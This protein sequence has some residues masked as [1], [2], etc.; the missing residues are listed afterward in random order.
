MRLRCHK[1]IRV[2]DIAHT[3]SLRAPTQ[4]LYIANVFHSHTRLV[5]IFT[6]STFGVIS[7]HNSHK[8]GQAATRGVVSEYS[9]FMPS[10]EGPPTELISVVENRR[11]ERFRTF[12]NKM[13]LT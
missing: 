12:A 8:H 2:A 9:K 1:M 10:T 3:L 4:K 11:H 6:Q 5:G 7:P 13:C